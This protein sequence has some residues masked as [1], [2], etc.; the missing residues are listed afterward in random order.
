MIV[1]NVSSAYACSGAE[2]LIV[3]G[4]QIH[5][6][7][8]TLGVLAALTILTL[9]L[10]NFATSAPGPLYVAAVKI[11]RLNVGHERAAPGVRSGPSSHRDLKS[12]KIAERMLSTRTQNTGSRTGRGSI[13]L[14]PFCRRQGR[15]IAALP[16]RG[17]RS[18]PAIAPNF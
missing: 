12:S 3:K 9:S 2:P 4:F 5:G 17:G 7:S 11:R 18:D 16:Y 10:P 1:C 15:V 6:A 14:S 8:A 13:G